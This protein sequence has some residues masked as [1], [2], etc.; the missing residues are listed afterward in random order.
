MLEGC[1][2]FCVRCRGHNKLHWRRVSVK[3]GCTEEE[4]HEL[5]LEARVRFHQV[6]SR[7]GGREEHRGWEKNVCPGIGIHKVT[8]A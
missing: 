3:E 8:L 6:L 7:G 1:L 5:D 2:R 4:V